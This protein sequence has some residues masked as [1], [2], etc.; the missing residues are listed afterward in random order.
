MSVNPLVGNKRRNSSILY[1]GHQRQAASSSPAFQGSCSRGYTRGCG[2]SFPPNKRYRSIE[3]AELKAVEDPFGDTEDFTADDLEEIEILATQA[4]TQNTSPVTDP[5]RN[6]KS[7]ILQS[8]RPPVSLCHAT[9]LVNNSSGIAACSDGKTSKE[10]LGNSTENTNA[11]DVFG[12]EVLQAQYE[13]L[14][15]KLNELQKDILIKNGENKVLRDSLRQTES[16]LEQEKRSHSVLEKERAQIQSEKEKEL[17]KKL[18][19]L[20]SELHFKDA[21][22]N[23]LRTKLQ[24]WERMNKPVPVPI[25]CNSPKK[26]PLASV[27]TE[28]CSSPQTE[29]NSF[30]TKESFT[31]VMSPKASSSVV[32]PLI[33][34]PFKKEDSKAQILEPEQVKTEVIQK[35]ISCSSFQRQNSQGS[36]LLNALMQQPKAPGSL[37]LYHLLSSNPDPLPG[38]MLQ[39]NVFSSEAT[40]ASSIGADSSRAETPLSSLRE[41]QKLAI[42]GLNLIVMDEGLSDKDLAQNQ[43]DFFQ[44]NRLCK[45]AGAVHLLPLVEH[46]ISVYCHALQAMEKSGTGPSENP[47]LWSSST[48]RSIASSTDELLS[49]LEDSALASL[50]V[51]Y[52][53]VSYSQE[54]VCTLL[55][56]E[57]ERGAAVGDIL[58]LEMEKTQ[59]YNDHC[60]NE[61]SPSRPEKAI[62]ETPTQHPL[63]KKVLQLLDFNIAAVGCQRTRIVNQSLRVLVE[64]AGNATDGLLLFSF[65]KL[66]SSTVL[67]RCLS[68]DSSLSAV[69]LTVQ[70]LAICTDHP[71]LTAQLL[72]HSETCVFRALYLYIT[73]RPDKLASEMLWLLLEHE[74]VRFLTKLCEQCP[75]SLTALVDSPCQCSREVVKAL[76]V[77]LHQQW[78]K[79]RRWD[80][81]PCLFKKKTVQFLRDSVL[82]LHRLSQRGKAYHE[83][84]LEVLHQYD[85]ALPGVRSIFKNIPDLKE[86]EEIAVDELCP[87]E[88][89]ADEQDMDCDE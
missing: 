44:M 62:I 81:H 63:F 29:K 76:I 68:P 89:D 67:W 19:S 87:P 54:V 18:K 1:G 75:Q 71:K 82:L 50:S 52:Y 88:P 69:R 22:M 25:S 72:S 23:E 6:E 56:S 32:Q 86:I 34:S 31:A 10:L 47:S 84:C 57:T 20:Q 27:K 51:L 38:F 17:S 65:Q 83:Q 5:K 21:E 12:F 33:H 48:L 66:V 37:G 80:I 36:I 58:T 40:G 79:V 73:S 49:S 55:S 16:D 26:S 30:P 60:N 15:Q 9:Q 85:Q 64:L 35:N 77:M 43:R 45:L 13:E 8:T 39:Q 24:N 11:N 42:T 4:L 7:K 14:K 59:P 46:Y 53:L 28:G 61:P 2:E 41:A 70:L 74:V 78:L 3:A